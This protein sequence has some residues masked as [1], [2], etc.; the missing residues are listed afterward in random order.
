MKTVGYR[1]YVSKDQCTL[2]Q[3]FMDIHTGLIQSVE[4]SKRETPLERWEP[5]ETLREFN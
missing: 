2:V 4:V 1:M 5:T 3:L